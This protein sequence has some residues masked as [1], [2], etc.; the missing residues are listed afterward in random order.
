MKMV[1]Q[2]FQNSP[3]LL[4][5]FGVEVGAVLPKHLPSRVKVMEA[6]AEHICVGV[7]LINLKRDGVGIETSKEAD[8]SFF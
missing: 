6:H 7:K 5:L 3:G 8:I 1:K 4:E 2:I